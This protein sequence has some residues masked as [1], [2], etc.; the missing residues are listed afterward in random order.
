MAIQEMSMFDLEGQSD[1][2]P[3][4]VLNNSKR[5]KVKEAGNLIIGIPKMRGSGADALLIE[6][7]WLPT[8][9][10]DRIRREQ[11]LTSSEFRDAVFKRLVVLID[12][13]TAE[14]LLNKPE[15]K[16][17]RARLDAIASNINA[18]GSARTIAMANVTIVGQDGTVEQPEDMVNMNG[19]DQKASDDPTAGIEPKFKGWADRLVERDDLDVKTEVQAQDQLRK[20][21][22]LYLLHILAEDSHPKTIAMLNRALGRK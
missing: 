22:V 2:D 8:R 4:W 20:R 17:E 7:T 21:E 10:T 3:I 5:S 16:R 15:A 18:A 1:S 6:Q 14:R 12:S 9:I 13:K 11:L 19:K